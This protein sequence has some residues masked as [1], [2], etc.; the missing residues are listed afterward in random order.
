MMKLILILSF[1]FTSILLC[2]QVMEVSKDRVTVDTLR[3]DE[4]IPDWRKGYE[5]F[6]ADNV[7]ADFDGI[8]NKHISDLLDEDSTLEFK[9]YWKN[10]VTI[11]YNE[12][13]VNRLKD[14]LWLCVLDSIH[15]VA[16]IPVKKVNVTSHFGIRY[17]RN[18]NG[19]D[20]DLE[21]GDTVFAAFDGVIRYG[22]YHP[23]GFGN[24]VIA[25]HFNGFETYYAHLS[26]LLVKPNEVIRAG[27][28][29]GLGGNTG[30]SSGSHL[31][32]E[33]RF[34]DQPIDPEL[35][36]DFGNGDI[37]SPNFFV[38]SGVFQHSKSSNSGASTG[39]T[40]TGSRK[41]HKVRSGDTLSG[42]AQKNRTSVSRLCKLNRIKQS[43]TLR[44]GQTIRLR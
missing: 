4:I 24:L 23:N 5:E 29:I 36:F 6:D 17:G 31:H 9:S 25:R 42:I 43:S 3:H 35:V 11:T 39:G 20:L 18:H 44:I 1:S 33:V 16:S 12:N 26:K 30:R 8:L 2:A 28:P 41:Y 40:S 22:K 32:F 7:H 37:K 10:N 27:E 14:T 38:H 13:P 19:T 21:T 34:Y 15:N